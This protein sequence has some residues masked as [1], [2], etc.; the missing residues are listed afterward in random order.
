MVMKKTYL[1]ITLV[2]ILFG[3]SCDKYLEVDSLSVNDLG[4]IF[5]NK[6]QARN[7]I[8]SIYQ[9]WSQETNRLLFY[10]NFNT[11]VEMGKVGPN[12]DNGRRDLWAYDVKSTNSYMI[13]AWRACYTGA[14]R[15]NNAIKGIKE[16]DF[17][18]DGDPDIMHMLGEAYTLRAYWYS[19]LVRHWG[20]IPFKVTPWD[21]S[22]DFYLAGT[23][24]DL[25]LSQLID[26]LIEVEPYMKWAPELPYGVHMASRSYAQALI[27]RIAL[28]RGGYSLRPARDGRA[29]ITMVRNDDYREYYQIANTYCKKLI[30]SGMHALNLPYR[31]VFLNQNYGILVSNDDMIFEVAYRPGVGEVG[32]VMGL[33]VNTGNHDYGKGGG[34]FMLVPSYVYSFD[35]L[36]ARLPATAAFY[37]YNDNLYQQIT[38]VTDIEIAKWSKA[39]LPTPPGRYS[40]QGDGINWPL[41]RYADVLLMYAETE[42][43]LNNGP[44]EAAKD[45]LRQVRQRAFAPEHWAERVDGYI[46]AVSGS[47]ETFFEAIV[48][49][50]A[51]ELGG[52]LVRKADLYAGIWSVR[53]YPKHAPL[54]TNGARYKRWKR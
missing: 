14:D 42:N 50:R 29:D 43:E 21:A 39:W 1:F 2:F 41:M 46:N 32:Y 52:E 35:S 54:D 37:F 33:K 36:D 12:Y 17:Y 45:A 9:P 44:T 18:N 10:A 30:E 11:D 27:A 48:N 40:V 6:E 13:N 25:I 7:F 8:T 34:V 20:D 5:S 3:T 26:D 49:E 28:A 4:Y 24:R 15:A 47:K 53:K 22:D 19:Q 23:D 31:T 51:W 38:N 16:S